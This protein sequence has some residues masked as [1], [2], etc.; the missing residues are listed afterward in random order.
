MILVQGNSS[1][2][3]RCLW[4]GVQIWTTGLNTPDEIVDTYASDL[5]IVV[6]SKIEHLRNDMKGMYVIN[7][8]SYDVCEEAV[9]RGALC[10]N[11]NMKEGL[12]KLRHLLQV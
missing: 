4:N 5:C 10:L 12:W 1:I 7:E 9:L 6:V 3:T 8:G 11:C 2:V